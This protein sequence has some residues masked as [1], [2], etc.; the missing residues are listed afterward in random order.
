M[1]RVAAVPAA[2]PQQTAASRSAPRSGRRPWPRPGCP[3]R[4][5]SRAHGH[6]VHAPGRRAYQDGRGVLLPRRATPRRPRSAPGRGVHGRRRRSPARRR[7]PPREGGEL[8]HAR[9]QDQR[10]RRGGGAPASPEVSTM[11]APPADRMRPRATRSGEGRRS[12]GGSRSGRPGTSA[13]PVP[14][15]GL[16]L[17]RLLFRH[18]RPGHHEPV[19]AARRA[20][21]DGEALAGVHGDGDG[22]RRHALRARRSRSWAP[23]QPP[24]R[25]ST[26]TSTPS[27]WA[28]RATF[29]PP[30]RP[31]GT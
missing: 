24:T 15:R 30:P 7:G 16:R 11:T 21:Q 26:V 31:P 9:L 13:W 10:P 23:A 3:R 12:A 28:T 20:F 19:L 6:V 8:P 4:R 1:A 18:G 29:T 14:R 5:P 27:T 22:L 2:T 17:P 25:T